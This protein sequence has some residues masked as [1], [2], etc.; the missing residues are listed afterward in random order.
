MRFG[1]FNLMNQHGLEQ[2]EVFEGTIECARLADALGFDI[3]WFAEHHFSNYSL[4]P[5]PLMMAAAVARET[6]RIRLGPAVIV[7]PL[8]NPIRVA[9]EVALL[10][11]LSRGRAVL[12]IGSGYQR[13]EFDAFGA[14]LAERQERMLEIWQ[15]IDQAVHHNRFQHAGRMYQL[16]DVPQAI[17]LYHPR[18]LE[19]FFVSWSAPTIH[20]AVATDA[21]PFCTVGWGDTAALTSL[22][23]HVA[24]QYAEAG[25]DLAG[26]RFAAQRY[27][28]VSD[29]KAE[30]MKVAEGIRYAGRCAGHMR[31]GAQVLDGHVIQDRPVAG[32]P[33]LEAILAGLP[34][35]APETVAERLVH[36]IRTIGITD[37]SCFMWP[38]GLGSRAVLR[39]MERFGAEVMPLVTKA[40]A[41]DTRQP[42]DAVA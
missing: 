39:S 3:A 18:R 32:E 35:G 27:V 26:R 20:H 25:Y 4:C 7:A 21:V 10:D 1:L 34:V 13:F 23:D 15:I 40:L 5:S 29:D 41:A 11:Q 38:A 6:R 14:D 33:T 8:Y 37:L 36:E 19:T 22:H 17:R 12:G 24:R 9:E 2:R 42:A 28:F 31:V 30:L 16:P